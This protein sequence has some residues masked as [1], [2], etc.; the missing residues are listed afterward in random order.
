MWVLHPFIDF[1]HGWHF[2]GNAHIQ[3]HF[4]QKIH[5][6]Q[7]LN[8]EKNVCKIDRFWINLLKWL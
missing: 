3:T 7:N 8:T 6:K 1:D 2:A 4:K 5:N